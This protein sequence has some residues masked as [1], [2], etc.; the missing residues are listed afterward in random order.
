MNPV[1]G[2]A[3]AILEGFDRHYR[4]FREISAAARGRFENANWAGGAEANRERIQMYDLR[5]RETVSALN[6]TFPEAE[7]DDRLWPD[8]KLAYIGLLYEHLRPELAETFFN[9]VA[10]RVL[11]RWYYHNRYIFWRPA[12]ST[13]LIEGDEPTYRCY[14]PGTNGLRR[15]LLN[16]I[17]DFRLS[18][19][20]ANLKHDTRCLEASV[21][22]YYPNRSAQQPNYQIQV[23]G[24]LFF[25]NKAAYIVGRVLNANDLLP[26]AI[27]I[28]Q[29]SHGELYLDTVIIEQNLLSTLFSFN[30][31][32]FMVD[33]DVPSAYVSFLQS[34][35]PE[36]PEFEIY[37]MLGLQKQGK[38]M[39]YRELHHHLR[40]SSDNFAIAPGIRGMVMLVFTLPSFPYV[41]KIIR[42][43]FEPPKEADRQ[44][45]KDKYLLVKYHDRAG[46]LADTLEYSQVA[47]PLNRISDELLEELKNQAN[48]SIEITA[49]EL[50]VKHLYIERRM[51]PLNEYMSTVEGEEK[52]RAIDEYGK[53]IRELAGANIFPGDM[54]LKN[55]GVTRGRRVV[56][57]DYDE[58]CYM[59][60]CNFR[61]IPPPS[62]WDDEMMDQPTYSVEPNDVFPEQFANFFFSDDNTRNEFYRNHRELVEPSFWR[63]KK[64]RILTGYHEDILPYPDSKRF[65]VVYPTPD[66]LLR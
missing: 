7:H 47:F 57:Y 46:R 51:I 14:Y 49:D 10:C 29:N 56:F 53:A 38:T 9:S 64:Q 37:S 35:L 27:P 4:L 44:T 21:K 33:M 8:I 60:D 66:T 61:R 54:M 62:S 58:I 59:T 50:L 40:Y 22:G 6:A 65:S 31:A 55:F 41:F 63:D 30:R 2:I 26:F 15:A 42:D 25:R 28:L 23:L 52:N 39:F 32:Y 1:S 5:V 3:E 20:F 19:K 13:V 18:N 11:H 36:K 16:C 48:S 45:V 12:T 34:V 43:H 17:T 24:S